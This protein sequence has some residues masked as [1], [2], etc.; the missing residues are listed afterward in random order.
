MNRL[1]ILGSFIPQSLSQPLLLSPYPL[2]QTAAGFAL[3]I[4]VP[5]HNELMVRLSLKLSYA[6]ISQ[7][8]AVLEPHR[9]SMRHSRH[10]LRAGSGGRSWRTRS[11]ANLRKCSAWMYLRS[12]PNR[13]RNLQPFLF[14]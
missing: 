2:T 12:K 13:Q 3:Y 4:P 7:S 1:L 10:L 5:A 11:S 8:G 14:V 6:R 9:L